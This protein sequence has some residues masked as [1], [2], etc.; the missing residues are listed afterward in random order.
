[1]FEGVFKTK[2]LKKLK[3]TQSW[4]PYCAEEYVH[5]EDCILEGL[6]FDDEDG[7][8]EDDYFDEENLW[9]NNLED[10]DEDCQNSSNY[11]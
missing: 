2:L 8:D 11:D 10:D 7:L 1:M 6:W 9:S 5:E 3:E 4:C